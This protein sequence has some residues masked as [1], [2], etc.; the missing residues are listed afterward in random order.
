M[1]TSQLPVVDTGDIKTIDFQQILGGASDTAGEEESEKKLAEEIAAKEEEE[2]AAE[3]TLEPGTEAKLIKQWLER[4]PFNR[5]SEDG[6]NR[7][8]VDT[9]VYGRIPEVMPTM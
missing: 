3:I 5:F 7:A 2:A 8:R 6:A 1:A 9:L 4:S